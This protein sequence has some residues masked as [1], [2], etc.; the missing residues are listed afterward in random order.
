M[1]CCPEALKEDFW[2]D[3]LSTEQYPGKVIVFAVDEA[4]NID[5]WQGFRPTYKDL[6]DLKCITAEGKPL[7]LLTA[8]CT[9]TMLKTISSSIGMECY[10]LVAA[11]PDRSVNNIQFSG[12]KGLLENWTVI[13]ISIISFC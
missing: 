9:Q 10:E 7:L 8:T 4:H 13:A 6:S 11:L 12:R 5:E 3:A 1:L 2:L